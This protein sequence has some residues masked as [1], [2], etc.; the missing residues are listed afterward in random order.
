MS[1]KHFQ[2]VE[3]CDIGLKGAKTGEGEGRLKAVNYYCKA[4]QLRCLQGF[5]LCLG[6]HET[7]F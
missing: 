6:N 2:G 7:M 5:S 4:L 1:E 3:K